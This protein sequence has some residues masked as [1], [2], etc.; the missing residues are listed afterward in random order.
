M[1]KREGKTEWIIEVDEAQGEA[2]Y[3]TIGNRL[4]VEGNG[5]TDNGHFKY[6]VGKRFQVVKRPL[7]GN[8]NDEEDLILLE[9]CPKPQIEQDKNTLIECLYF[10]TRVESL[11]NSKNLYHCE[12]CN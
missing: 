4:E 8:K 1:D 12:N 7:H 11:I 3:E 5:H 9:P 6:E 2:V 10:A